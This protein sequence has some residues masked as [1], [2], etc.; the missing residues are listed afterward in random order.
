MHGGRIRFRCAANLLQ[1][2]ERRYHEKEQY[3]KARKKGQKSQQK[4]I[5]EKPGGAAELDAERPEVSSINLR[6]PKPRRKNVHVNHRRK[7]P[8]KGL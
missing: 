3:E 2:E 1:L 8:I 6:K 7:K 5:E 4:V